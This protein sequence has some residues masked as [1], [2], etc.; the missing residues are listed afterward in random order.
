MIAFFLV[1]FSATLHATWNSIGKGIKI[2]LKTLVYVNGFIIIILSPLWFIINPV[3]NRSFLVAIVFSGLFQLLYQIFLCKSY[4]EIDISTAY[5]LIR[6]FPLVVV[7]I[8]SYWLSIGS[9]L[10]FLAYLGILV[11][12]LGC[13]V[14]SYIYLKELKI[15]K[16][17]LL[18]PLYSAI[19]IAGYTISDYYGMNILNNLNVGNKILISG[20]YQFLEIGSSQILLLLYITFV[21]KKHI[22]VLFKRPPLKAPLFI[23][24]FSLS[25]YW[26]ILIAMTFAKNASYI[27]A[28]RQ[29]SIPISVFIGIFFLKEQYYKSRVLGTLLIIL[30]VSLVAIK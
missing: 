22:K 9:K 11:I 3:F 24:I 14:T 28:F 29:L 23:A 17:I 27:M 13:L 26:I 21:E 20:V 10:T 30:G 15:D 2:N 19:G 4:E 7:P 12:I 16:K 5:P 8:I 1:L 25:S 18:Y 6:A